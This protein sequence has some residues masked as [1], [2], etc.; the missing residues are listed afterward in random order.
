MIR[1]FAGLVLR[2]KKE[3]QKSGTGKIRFREDGA[4]R[5]SASRLSPVSTGTIR[6]FTLIELLIV[7][8]II[9]ILAGMLLPALNKAREMA[10]KISCVNSMSSLGKGYIMY[11]G[12]YSYLAPFRVGNRAWYGGNP[13]TGL[14]A[15]Y[16]S[17]NNR[18]SV[19]IGH[20]AHWY[21]QV[22]QPIERSQISCPVLDRLPLQE[23]IGGTYGYGYNQS[24][25]RACQCP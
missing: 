11:T 25:S 12:D 1:R 17:L 24:S 8:A 22:A 13:D 3:W 23:T 18:H 9:A 5:F 2:G 7:V 4:A 10:Y 14:L 6:I 15:T 21:G 16:L 20:R 19:N